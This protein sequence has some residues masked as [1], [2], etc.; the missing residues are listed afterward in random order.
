MDH[1]WKRTS[2][3]KFMQRRIPSLRNPKTTRQPN[4][5]T[6]GM[7]PL[8][9][10]CLMR[11]NRLLIPSSGS[12]ISRSIRACLEH[13]QLPAVRQRAASLVSPNGL[14]SYCFACLLLALRTLGFSAAQV[15]SIFGIS[16]RLYRKFEDALYILHRVNLSCVSEAAPGPAAPTSD[17]SSDEELDDKDLFMPDPYLVQA[18]A[19]KS[20]SK[21]RHSPTSAEQLREANR[22]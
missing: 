10:P 18:V 5:P 9:E 19:L 7:L 6:L 14:R 4:P 15:L 11:N 1:E 13:L 12:S 22:Q 16:S 17:S 21:K 2:K 3:G 20:H 8:D